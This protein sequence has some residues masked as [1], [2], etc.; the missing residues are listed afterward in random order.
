VIF[1]SDRGSEY[2][3]TV[4]PERL[5]TLGLQQSSALLGPEN[6]PQMHSFVPSLQGEP[7]HGERLANEA[8]LRG[9]IA[10]YMRYCHH[11]R[12]PSALGYRTPV[13]DEGSSA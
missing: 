11:R 4:V 8:A 10:R 5:Q 2:A 13:D 6:H 3:A 9:A 1:H 12:M 7:V